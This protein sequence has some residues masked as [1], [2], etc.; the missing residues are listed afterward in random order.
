M[1]RP[2]LQALHFYPKTKQTSRPESGDKKTTSGEYCV[3]WFDHG[4]NMADQQ[5]QYTIKV[6][7][8]YCVAWFDH[9]VNMADQQYR[10]IVKVFMGV[11]GNF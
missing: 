11:L 7:G 4:V 6:S 2:D 5:Y 3:A 8:E 10:Y 1:P 9:G